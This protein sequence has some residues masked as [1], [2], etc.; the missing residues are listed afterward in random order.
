MLKVYLDRG[1]RE[2]AGGAMCVSAAIF[3]PREYKQF[4]R[5]WSLMLRQIPGGPYPYM[6]A[7]DFFPGGG[8]FKEILKEDR[9]LVAKQ[10]PALIDRYVYQFV[11]AAFK[12]EE[13]DGAAPASWR[14]QFG[15]LHGVAAQM[16]AGAIG[17]WA[18]ERGYRGPIWYFF[19]SG[20]MDEEDVDYRFD[21]VARN[22]RISKHVRY[23]SHKFLKKGEARGLEAADYFAWHWN[24]FDAETLSKWAD[25]RPFRDMR[26]DFRALVARNPRKYRVFRFVGEALSD[27]LIRFGCQRADGEAS[28]ERVT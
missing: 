15:S 21:A 23:H 14:E 26:K 8:K 16:C 4:V 3:K 28:A 1:A 10:L 7:T 24:K 25:D 18:D 12:E 5:A 17:H 9:E 22:G 13:F 11:T 6:H 19:E 27:F 2:D 20:D